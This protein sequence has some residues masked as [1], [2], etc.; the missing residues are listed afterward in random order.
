[1]AKI[2][3]TSINVAFIEKP[4]RGH[5]PLYYGAGEGSLALASLNAGDAAALYVGGGGINQAFERILGR[6]QNTA[7]YL[8]RHAALLADTGGSGEAF[9]RYDGDDPTA[10]SYLYA[11]KVFETPAGHEGICFVDVFAPS[12]RPAGNPHNLAMLYVA[13]PNGHNHPG[14]ADFLD[15]IGRTA[16]NIATT[17]ARYNAL[18]SQ[19][20]LESIE[21]LRLCLYSPAIYNPHN[22][23]R[24]K[25]ALAIFDGLCAG[26]AADDGGLREVQMPYAP[27]KD[28]GDGPL[29]RAVKTKLGG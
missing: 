1:V 12:R 16:K 29:F 23:S 17:V 11:A 2:G 28:D 26:L 7:Q 3:G 9:K 6:T 13:P 18:A 15:A 21:A 14:A 24:D 19:Q 10:F 22:V 20:K 27:E 25:I 8:A 5:V 4:A